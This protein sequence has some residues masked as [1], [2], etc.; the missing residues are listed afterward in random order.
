MDHKK[1][2]R[3][4]NARGQVSE[5][6]SR[7][8]DITDPSVLDGILKNARMVDQYVDDSL[9]LNKDNIDSLIIYLENDGNINAAK[10]IIRHFKYSGPSLLSLISRDQTLIYKLEL[11][12]STVQSFMV[13]LIKINDISDAT[14]DFYVRCIKAAFMNG[15]LSENT[16]TAI[17]EWALREDKPI[18]GNRFLK[19]C[20]K[21]GLLEWDLLTDIIN[22]KLST[23]AAYI[24]LFGVK[25]L[26]ALS[27][28]HVDIIKNL[29]VEN[30][31][32]GGPQRYNQ[33]WRL[34]KS[35][36]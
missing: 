7:I 13:G 32:D 19:L 14:L 11:P 10:Q 25:G 21:H 6:I 26:G 12:L 27:D 20:E 17:S 24:R 9:Y 34:V 30:K 31:L 1:K 16:A 8:W 23:S 35:E 5:M 22:A 28:E 36:D 18:N 33:L 4:K 2:A 3:L 29:S 15:R